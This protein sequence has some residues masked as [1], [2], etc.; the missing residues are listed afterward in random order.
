MERVYDRLVR[1]DE[2]SRAFPVRSLVP[3]HM[4]DPRSQEW[5]LALRL[6]QGRE[7]AC[8]GFAVAH[9]A[10]AEPDP[11]PDLT[12]ADAHAVYHRARQL[13]EWPGED[14]EGSSVIAAVQAGMERGWY[15]EYR[16]AFG[17]DDLVLALGWLGPAILGVSW[18]EGMEDP[19]RNGH[20]HA[21]GAELGGH[22]ITATAVDVDNRRVRLTNS[23]GPDWGDGGCA[24]IAWHDLDL[25]LGRQGEACVP[26]VRSAAA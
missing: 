3:E 5:P 18:Y 11:I 17:L 13:D 14:Y 7:G 15:H 16:W 9:E 19:D 24:W 4:R 8:T 23:W 6:D 22:A 26:V 2:R 10:A 20:L 25:L 12:E 21:D 1:F